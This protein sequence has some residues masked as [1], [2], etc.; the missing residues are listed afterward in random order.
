MKTFKFIM[1][2]KVLSPILDGILLVSKTLQSP[3]LDLVDGM[4]RINA[5][6]NSLQEIRNDDYNYHLVYEDASNLCADLGVEITAPKSRKVSIRIDNRPDSASRIEDAERHFKVFAFYPLLDSLLTGLR[7]RF[8]Q[9]TKNIITAVGKITQLDCEKNHLTAVVDQFDLN[10][11][12]LQ[13]EISL[14]KNSADR[15]RFLGIWDWLNW[16]NAVECR[17]QTFSNFR[18]L[19]VQFVSIPV[20][21]CSCERAFS[22]LNLALHKTRNTTTQERVFHILMPFIEQEIASGLNHDD[23]IDEFVRMVEFDRRMIL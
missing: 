15:P 2:L 5:L 12:T 17:M 8:N 11:S 4:A 19:L 9:E 20:T 7:E 10:L 22:K 13:A 1:S 18:K 21:S 16:I 14:L 6:S 3:Q 23:V